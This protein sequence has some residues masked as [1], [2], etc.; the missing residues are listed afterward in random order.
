MSLSKQQNAK[1]R[2]TN[3]CY[4]NF[5]QIIYSSQC[6]QGAEISAAKHKKGRKLLGGA[7]KVRGRTFARFSK[8]GRKGAELFLGL[9]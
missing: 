5:L 7:G 2:F 8:K 4:I 6:C 3:T 9:V 1:S